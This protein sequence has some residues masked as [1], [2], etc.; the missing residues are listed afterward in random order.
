MQERSYRCIIR[1]NITGPPSYRDPNMC[2]YSITKRALVSKKGSEGVLM[3]GPIGTSYATDRMLSE[4]RGPRS[5][6]V[7]QV[8]LETTTTDHR[9]VIPSV[10]FV[11][12]N[13][14]MLMWDQW[15]ADDHTERHTGSLR[16]REQ[17]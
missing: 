5:D 11:E 13:P 3:R 2:N 7:R 12:I 17:T 1:I 14:V 15:V 4:F 10:E 16:P 9:S 8:A 6:Y